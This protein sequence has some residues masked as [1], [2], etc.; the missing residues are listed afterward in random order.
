MRV[1]LPDYGAFLHWPEPGTAWIHA[2]D[3]VRASDLIP[4]RRVFCRERFDGTYYH[5]RY[6]EARLRIRPVMWLSLES[7]GFDVGQQVEVSGVGLARE[8]F[9]GEIIGMEYYRRSREIRY[10]VRRA[11]VVQQRL[12]VASE[13]KT[14]STKSALSQSDFVENKLPIV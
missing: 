11:G 7:D 4:S 5:L 8:P 12:Y 14:V 1:Q 6:G 2:D 9:V 13:L 3:A 10:T